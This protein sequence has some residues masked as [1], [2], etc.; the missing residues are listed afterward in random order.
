MAVAACVVLFAFFKPSI[1]FYSIA[2][3]TEPTLRGQSE[4][5]RCFRN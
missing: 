3:T 1:F 2:L 4:D 5:L